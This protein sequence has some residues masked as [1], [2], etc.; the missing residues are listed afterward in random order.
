[1]ASVKIASICPHFG[2]EPPIS[3]TRGS[4]T[5]FFSHCTL[6]CV[7]CQNYQISSEGIG[8]STSLRASKDYTDEKGLEGMLHLQELGCHNVNLVSPTQ[9]APQV[10]R[11]IKTAKNRGLR[12]PVVYNTNGYDSLETLK[13]FDG[14]V[15]IYLPDIKYS[16][17]K[18]AFELS[19]VNDYVGQNRA[20]IA[21]MYRQVGNLVLDDDGIAIK[22]L[23][24]RHL[25]LP[26]GLA[27]S[28]ASLKFLASLSKGIWLSIM[29]Q[30]HPCF[31]AK[32][33]EAINRR[34]NSAEYDQVLRWVDEFGF[35]NVLAQELV[36]SDVYLP[37]FS[38]KQ[39]F[40]V[41][42]R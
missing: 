26:N 18:I 34:I 8:P 33:H 2:E 1:M 22:G 19:G 12:I 14:L 6:K 24:V 42:K 17:D 28:Y 35:E 11:I 5:I 9:Y 7:Y 40:S 32:E 37:D 23:L 10:A 21:E 38:K 16:D 3:G 30:Y 4:G 39:P 20:A 25:V 41:D 29:A 31:K 13:L 15:D 27:G 36:S